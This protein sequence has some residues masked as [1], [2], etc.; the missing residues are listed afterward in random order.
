MAALLY[1]TQE[2]EIKGKHFGAI[3]HR[4]PSLETCDSIGFRSLAIGFVMLTAGIALG[5]F[6]AI[7]AERNPVVEPADRARRGL[8]VAGVFLSR[9]LPTHVGV[10]RTTCRRSA[11]SLDS[12]WS[13]SA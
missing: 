7:P 9:A 6:W 13:C 5:M 4:L 8:H 1:I 12:D 3:F 10:A 11:P 2:R